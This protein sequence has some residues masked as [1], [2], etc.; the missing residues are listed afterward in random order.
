LSAPEFWR[1]LP[2]ANQVVPISE[3]SARAVESKGAVAYVSFTQWISKP[4]VRQD[5][6]MSLK[7]R[8]CVEAS[9]GS[10]IQRDVSLRVLREYLEAWK[11]SAEASHKKNEIIISEHEIA[12]AVDS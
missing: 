9:F 11:A 5:S 2:W 1:H 8:I 10:E 6:S 12:D 4:A 7:F 3:V